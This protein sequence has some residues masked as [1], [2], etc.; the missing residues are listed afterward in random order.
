MLRWY[1]QP[2][3]PRDPLNNPLVDAEPLLRVAGGLRVYARGLWQV[4]FP[5]TLSGDYSAPQEPIP[6]RVAFPES[7]VGLAFMTVPPLATLVLGVR[8]WRRPKSGESAQAYA[9]S[10]VIAVALTW[11]AI[12]Y[13]PVSNIPVVLPTVRAERFWYFPAIGTSV[14]LA[15]VFDRLIRQK[16]LLGASCL[17]AFLLFQGICARKHANDYADDLA[18][19]DATRKAVPRSAKAHLNYSVMQG[20]RGHLD[21]RLESN[22]TALELAPDWPMASVYLGDTLCRLHKPFEAW[23]YYEKGFGLASGDINLIA[24]GVQCLWDEQGLVEDSELR[25]KLEKVGE[26]HPGSWLDY[27]ARDTLDNGEAHGGVD[28]KYRPRGYNEGP[29]QD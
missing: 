20:A 7:M 15:L 12:S 17:S 24:L 8:A 3:L 14:V 13:F 27:I 19:W 10:L 9:P 21:I 16:R 23:P 1:A 22:K 5:W 11:I 2:A 25:G 4:I 6:A 18:F 28:P 26:A 29:K